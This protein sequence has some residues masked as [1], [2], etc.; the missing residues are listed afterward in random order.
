MGRNW[1]PFNAAWLATGEPDL[2]GQPMGAIDSD[3]AV[4]VL[5]SGAW[6]HD[7]Y[8]MEYP[9]VARSG[10][11]P[12]VHYLVQ[13]W[14]EDRSPGPLFDS[15]LY[16]TNYLAHPEGVHPLAHYLQTGRAR[17]LAP[18]EIQHAGFAR[19]GDRDAYPPLEIEASQREQRWTE[20]EAAV[21]QEDFN[22]A[23]SM[24]E[25]SVDLC[26]RDWRALISL[27]WCLCELHRFEEAAATWA[28]PG[29]RQ[30]I[31]HLNCDEMS[32]RAA[33]ADRALGFPERETWPTV[34]YTRKGLLPEPGL[35]FRGL[36]KSDLASVRIVAA[37]DALPVFR[38]DRI[39]LGL[40]QDSRSVL[41]GQVSD[42]K[43]IR[44]APFAR[45]Q[46]S[47]DCDTMW[48]VPLWRAIEEAP[49]R[50]RQ[51]F[52]LNP[53]RVGSTLLVKM[54]REAGVE[55]ISELETHRQAA[56]AFGSGALDVTSARALSSAATSSAL[57]LP[58]RL[59]VN[60]L[61]AL[62]CNAPASFMND[63][64]DA[65]VLWRGLESWFN[66]WA[67]VA[68]PAIDPADPLR[69]WNLHERLE[70][71]VRAQWLV[72]QEG[73][74]TGVLWFEDLAAG[75]LAPAEAVF[76]DVLGG[77]RLRPT[78]V[79]SQA[80]T[81]LS[82]Q[83][84]AGRSTYPHLWPDF[85]ARWRRSPAFGM[86]RELSLSG[87]TEGVPAGPAKQRSAAKSDVRTPTVLPWHAY[88]SVEH[89][90]HFLLGYLLPVALWQRREEKRRFF[91]RDCGP[92]NRLFGELA[93]RWN[94]GF[95]SPDEHRDECVLGGASYVVGMDQI[96][97][98][99]ANSLE[100]ATRNVT[101]ALGLAE[102]SVPQF[103]MPTI[104]VVERGKAHPFYA[105][106]RSESST[107]G[108]DRRSLPNQAEMSSA[109]EDLGHV[110]VVQ[111]EDASLAEQVRWFGQADVVVAQHGAALAN[112][113]W[114]RPGS[115]I[116]QIDPT[117][118][119]RT[120]SRLAETMGC[121]SE[122]IR[123]DSNHAAVCVK[124]VRKSVEDLLRARS[125]Q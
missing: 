116:V 92:L 13:G 44:D 73:R 46:A 39:I 114:C 31:Q 34:E 35:K 100:S 9:D 11:D 41:F 81:P 98:Y 36:V 110:Q 111:L 101:Q 78:D 119:G 58:C 95:L 79:D 6:D 64:D 103:E 84:L 107:S 33:L 67:R 68:G 80:G 53:G 38:P 60:K 19:C 124:T 26:P 14:R 104:L 106:S 32:L 40:A 118:R 49:Q 27:S 63:D 1:W 61:H 87:L 52:I 43:R 24:L 50:Q 5:A 112:I 120:F 3:E 113:V 125:R 102:W 86:A 37:D 71:V 17:G 97:R 89:Y 25:P 51:R 42:K 57:D 21:R 23:V 18:R 77:A 105:S 122:W 94:L 66:S 75:D 117:D 99:N 70:E 48:D 109:L 76:K 123:Q 62:A 59:V 7:W 69:P 12:L 47:R 115:G 55:A 93:S 16:H 22:T 85:A 96:T 4:L 15:R 74:L 20:A 82:R 121:S 83:S 90:Y 30:R 2:A 29:L 108:I 56:L 28:N 45:W 72:A 10:I 65:V 54:L 8:L 91:V 88:G